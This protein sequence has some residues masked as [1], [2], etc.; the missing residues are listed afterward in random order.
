MGKQ[1]GKICAMVGHDWM[2]LRYEKLYRL[3][4]ET[5]VLYEFYRCTICGARKSIRVESQ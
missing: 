4:S 5:P 3:G 1:L 2:V